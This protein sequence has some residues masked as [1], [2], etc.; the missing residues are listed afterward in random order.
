[1]GAPFPALFPSVVPPIVSALIY[2][3]FFILLF[4]NMLRRNPVPFYVLFAAAG[5]LRLSGLED[6]VPQV[7]PWIELMASCYIGVAFYLVVMFTGALPRKWSFTKQ[8]LSVRSEISVLAGFIVLFHIFKVWDL[9]PLSFS[10]F[11]PFIWDNAAPIMTLGFGVVGPFLVICFLIP[12]ITSF[13]TVRN[14]MTHKKWKRTQKL[15]YPFMVLLVLQGILLA[16]G[17]AV[18][19]GPQAAEYAQYVATAVL[20]VIFG[21]TYA[22]LKVYQASVKRAKISHRTQK[23]SSK[24]TI[25]THNA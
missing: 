19:V 3:I 16:V 1:M 17:H 25:Q 9:V 15:A 12:W 22:G 24:P 6:A 2:V 11:W 10:M 5:A 14:S 8:L 4:D 23:R 7:A 13:K 20:Y 21:L 18:Y